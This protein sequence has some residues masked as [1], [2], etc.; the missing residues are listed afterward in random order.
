[1]INLCFYRFIQNLNEHY[2]LFSPFSIYLVLEF[3]IIDIMTRLF[4]WAVSQA[5]SHIHFP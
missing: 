5:V 1:M 2:L 3:S 4:L